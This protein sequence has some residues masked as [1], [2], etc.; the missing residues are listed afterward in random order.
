MVDARGERADARASIVLSSSSFFIDV[1]LSVELCWSFFFGGDVIFC[2]CRDSRRLESILAV[3]VTVVN[4]DDLAHPTFLG[5]EE[6][7]VHFLL[8]FG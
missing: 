8:G 5:V 3:A 7:E 4:A 2:A 6:T 1:S